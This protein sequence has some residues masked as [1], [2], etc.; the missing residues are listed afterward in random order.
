[1]APE[2]DSNA[3]FH[4]CVPL[5]KDDD[6]HWLSELQ[7]FVRSNMVEIF[8]AKKDDVEMD[9][10]DI[11][12]GQVGVR[13]A[14]CAKLSVDERPDGHAYFPQDLASV[15]QSV[16]DLQRRHFFKC[17]E[18][19]DD[20]R[21]SSRSLRGFATKAEGETQQY[22]ID[23]LRELGVANY[24]DKPGIKFYRNPA[25][26]SAADVIVKER[27]KVRKNAAVDKTSLV[28]PTD[29]STDHAYLLMKQVRPCRFKNS[30]RR[31]GPG[32]RGRDR[33]LGFPGIACR[34][35]SSKKNTGR[36][37][38]V[39]SKSLADNTANTLQTHLATCPRCPES[40]KSSLVYLSHRASIQKADLG[41]G[42]KKTFFKH[43]WDRLHV[44]RAWTTKK[45]KEVQVAT[46][47]E[48]ASSD[49]E[50]NNA[51][52][53]VEEVDD[54]V[55][56]AAQWLTKRDAQMEGSLGSRPKASRGRGLPSRKRRDNND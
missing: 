54:M 5:S 3:I 21:K 22:W 14:Y 26:Q 56:A 46:V 17:T 36:Y 43:I 42:W 28:R 24:E 16:S 13:C 45:A 49:E 8:S 41:G 31:G 25:V 12:E 44:E 52:S 27:T 40:V 33:A 4:A 10:E 50:D 55:K 29:V 6:L 1:M 30:D 15:Y 23:S 18:I 7:C 39:A 19:P 32:S 34:H 37:F 48:K 51:D 2:D 47:E 38:P 9:E 20:A 35:C 11:V 53:D